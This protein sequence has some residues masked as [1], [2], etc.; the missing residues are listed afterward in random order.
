MVSLRGMISFARVR[1]S[2]GE[3]NSMS[4]ES[5]TLLKKKKACLSQHGMGSTMI[6][7]H[8]QLTIYI[9]FKKKIYNDN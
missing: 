6:G 4:S 1:I 7:P 8:E 9:I 5:R 2:P 3:G